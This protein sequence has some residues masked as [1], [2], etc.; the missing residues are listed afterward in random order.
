M[1]GSAAIVFYSIDDAKN[2]VSTTVSSSSSVPMA[3]ITNS[4]LGDDMYQ[5]S[6]TSSQ[7]HVYSILFRE[8]NVV[9]MN[10]LEYYSGSYALNTDWVRSMAQ[11]QE[12]AIMN[13]M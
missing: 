7:P 6:S 10:Q 11:L 9:C 5:A 8:N 2:F 3:H 1:F 4:G 12:N 13:A